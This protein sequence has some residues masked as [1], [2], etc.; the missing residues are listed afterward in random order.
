MHYATL[1]TIYYILYTIYFITILICYYIRALHGCWHGIM[2]IVENV[3]VV[4]HSV[5]HIVLYYY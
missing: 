5:D 1:Y 2:N 3:V 4:I